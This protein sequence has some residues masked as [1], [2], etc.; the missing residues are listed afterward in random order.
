MDF[1]FTL[2]PESTLERTVALTRQAEAAGFTYGWLFDSHVLWRD[3]YPLLT[4]MAQATERMRLGT[5]VTNPGTRE[6]SVTA[7]VL[8]TLDELSNGR[9]DLGIGRGDSARRVL[10]KPPT[11]MATLE[12]AIRVIRDLVEGRV[13]T[14]EGTELQ[15]TWTGRW[16][17]PVW[18]AGYGPMALSMTGRIADG[19]ILQLADPDL[20]RWFV[21][22]VREA[23]VAAGRDA[24]SIEVQA[25]APLHVGPVAVGR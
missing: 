6:P 9:M 20:I 4:L 8:A 24:E 22:Q 7:S 1:G 14:Y 19:V 17:L 21:G 3:P 15:L 25:A 13:V 5:C 18:V 16:K 12:E 10:G 2:K 23:A 11:T